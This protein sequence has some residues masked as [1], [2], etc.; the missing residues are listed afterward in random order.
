MSNLPA[1][2]ALALLTVFQHFPP[3]PG[4][5]RHHARPRFF[6]FLARL[7]PRSEV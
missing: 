1:T 6:L 5:V 7:A 4:R 3:A 2:I